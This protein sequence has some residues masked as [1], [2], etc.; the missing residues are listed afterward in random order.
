[1]DLMESLGF[2]EVYNMLG[3]ITAWEEAGYAVA[4]LTEPPPPTNNIPA[5]CQVLELILP[6]V[7]E[8]HALFSIS[9]VVTNPGNS[10]V[11]CDIPI[12]FTLVDNPE[13]TI[14]YI[15]S[16]TLNP[17]ETKEVSFDEAVLD[18]EK[19]YWVQAGD[20]SQ[21]IAVY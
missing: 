21:L 18:E 15:I 1:M 14:T 17:G 16:V 10:Q 3:G 7:V 19:A 13:D 6:D 8:A 4:A 20:I 5:D 11:S 9:L 2:A 12:T